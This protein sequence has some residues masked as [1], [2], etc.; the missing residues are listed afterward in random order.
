MTIDTDAMLK[1]ADEALTESFKPITQS[2]A[3]R[4]AQAVKDLAE[5]V[6]TLRS[7]DGYARAFNTGFDHAEQQLAERIA[8]ARRV[9]DWLVEYDL[10]L[11]LA[12]GAD[13]LPRATTELA[14]AYIDSLAAESPVQPR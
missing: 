13:V 3:K 6:D 11:K 1:L 12:I 8:E 9:L 14:E 7:S 10:D 4:L 5:E 2:D